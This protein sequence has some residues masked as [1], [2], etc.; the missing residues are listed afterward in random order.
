MIWEVNGIVN[1]FVV[2]FIVNVMDVLFGMVIQFIDSSIENFGVWFWDFG[3]GNI[4]NEQNLSYVYLEVGIYSV[5]LIVMN[6]NGLN[7]SVFFEIIVQELF[8]LIFDLESFLIEFDVGIIIMVI[9][10]L[11]NIGQGDLFVMMS[12]QD[13]MN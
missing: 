12:S 11:C 2:F 3:D 1:L 5:V 4:L 6:C 10:N 8:V 9:F 7:I 13:E